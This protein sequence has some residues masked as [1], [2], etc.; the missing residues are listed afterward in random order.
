MFKSKK[1]SSL[2]P[3]VALAALAVLV[4]YLSNEIILK[5]QMVERWGTTWATFY[6]VTVVGGTAVAVAI[7]FVVLGRMWYE[8]WQRRRRHERRNRNPAELSP[9]EQRQEVH[10]NLAEVK[11]LQSDTSLSPE[12]RQQLDPMVREIADKQEFGTL[13]IVA[14]GTVS[15][16]KS[17]L[18][19]TLAGRNVFST[20]ARGGTT[21]TRN[22]IPWPGADRVSLVDTPGLG[23][24]DGE[25]RQHVAAQAAKNADIVLVVVDGPLRQSEFALIQTLGDMEK[26]ILVCLNK[27]DWYHTEKK[28]QLVTQI[29][30]QTKKF[31]Q[32]P[33][34]IAVRSHTTQQTRMRVQS[35]GSEIQTVVET[36]PDIEPLADRMMELIRDDG[37]RILLANL[38]LQ[39]RGLVEEARGRVKKSLD[40]Q[41]WQIVD[42]HMWGAAGAAALSPFPIVDLVAGCAV[43]T[44]MVLDLARVYRQSMNQDVAVQL[45]SELSK[46]LIGLLGG[47]TAT[48]AVGSM[49]KSIPGAGWAVGGI[50]QGLA[51]AIITR[52]I[53]SVFIDYFGNEMQEPEGGWADLARRKWEQMTSMKELKRTVEAA[54]F[55]LSA[56]DSG[57]ETRSQ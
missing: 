53:G 30:D 56:G 38:L 20:D 44:K 10:E 2:L 22:Q 24:V 16:G 47:V 39:S 29:A 25:D 51:Q 11:Q 19:N 17:S 4:I 3:L 23:E 15:S 18:L 36:P 43:S 33:D 35:D 52:W 13:E 55:H 5:Y 6:L 45:L 9:S 32:T 49:L 34:V 28:E 14:F 40:G 48:A 31:V 26:R 57:R 1:T 50:L 54:R 12:L 21:V 8:T 41:A 7:L 27:E 46:H 37:Q 42:Q